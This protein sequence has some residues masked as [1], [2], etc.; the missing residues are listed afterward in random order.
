MG[1]ALFCG[2]FWVHF[3]LSRALENSTDRIDGIAKEATPDLE[4]LAVQ[5]RDIVTEIVEDTLQGLE[6]P[7]AIDHIFGAVAQ[8]IQARTMQMMNPEN[9]LGAAHAVAEQVLNPEENV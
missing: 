9:L 8:M 1:L 6:P 2:G 4:D 5:M 7:R 3:S